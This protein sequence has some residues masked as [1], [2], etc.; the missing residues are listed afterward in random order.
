VIANTPENNRVWVVEFYSDRCPICKGLVPE[1]RRAAIELMKDFPGQITLGAVNSRVYHELAEAWGI[2]SYPW[3]TSFY[4]GEKIED[5]AGLGGWQSIYNWGK[6]K[7]D[8]KWEPMDGQVLG[9]KGLKD[10][11]SLG[12]AEDVAVGDTVV[13]TADEA[14]VASCVAEKGKEWAGKMKDKRGPLLGKSGVVKEVDTGRDVVQVT[15]DGGV[16]MWWAPVYLTKADGK[17]L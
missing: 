5:M 16:D 2:K 6:K 8:E 14:K 12:K 11:G 15:F 10:A 4:K 3:V 9:C 7:F 1:V 13:L 17:E